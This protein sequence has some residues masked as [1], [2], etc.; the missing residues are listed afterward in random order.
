MCLS[1]NITTKPIKGYEI[2]LNQSVVVPVNVT[3][4][5]RYI[6]IHS[7]KSYKTI[8]SLA[9]ACGPF[10]GKA[11]M[12]YSVL[13]SSYQLSHHVS[14]YLF[15]P[16]MQNIEHLQAFI[17]PSTIPPCTKCIFGVLA[18]GWFPLLLLSCFSSNWASSFMSWSRSM[19][20]QTSQ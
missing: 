4:Y 10:F 1:K 20:D 12:I 13:H 8:I 2:I 18:P 16:L 14:V 7:L 6:I 9:L 17:C 11:W 19:L 15:L 3:K 5:I